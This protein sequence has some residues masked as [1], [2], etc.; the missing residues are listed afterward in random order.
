MML[1]RWQPLD[2]LETLHSKLDRV[3]DNLL[4]SDL[5]TASPWNPPIEIVEMPDRLILRAMLP[6]ITRDRIDIHATRNALMIAGEHPY[7]DETDDRSFVQTEFAYG[8]FQREVR[9]PGEIDPQAIHAEF[10]DGIL[11]LTLPKSEES[12]R[13]VVKVNINQLPLE[14]AS[15]E[16][17]ASQQTMNVSSEA[18]NANAS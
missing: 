9:L 1:V 4:Q 12:R 5:E 18:L 14:I 11:M 8:K 3:F 7:P 6:G 10:Q 17:G 13:R 15:P 2:R 16:L